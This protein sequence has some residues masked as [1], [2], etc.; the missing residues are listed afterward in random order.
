MKKE[1]TLPANIDC[2]EKNNLFA[3]IFYGVLCFFSMPFLVMFTS[4]GYWQEGKIMVWYEL[5]YHVLNFVVVLG[6]F[7]EYLQDAF[8]LFGVRKKEIFS[9]VRIAVVAMLAVV[10]V[11]YLLA[12][13]TNSYLFQV[14]LYG[15]LP[16]T[17][18]DVM[19]LSSIMPYE[20]PLVGIVI[21][22][23]L[24][25]LITV[26]LYYLPGFVPAFNVRPWLGYLCV[27]VVLAIPRISNASTHWD[28][29]D[30]AV[31][32]FAQLPVHLIA[33]WSFRK[34]ENM[35]APVLSLMIANG[36]ACARMIVLL[37]LGQ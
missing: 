17:E 23:F 1:I 37:L 16:L 20:N 35:F 25:P 10:G 34:T 32:Y 33:C 36:L 15:T 3:A 29:V 11:W 22:M 2:P 14:A 7:R 24:S 12:K 30:E 4:M 8:F 28:P 13:L 31:L 21:T 6:L 18:M 19:M 5:A 9:T 26:C 27:A